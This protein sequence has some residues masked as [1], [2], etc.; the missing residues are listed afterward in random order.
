MTTNNTVTSV[1]AKHLAVGMRVTM[2]SPDGKG[3][4]SP[5]EP[6]TI[7]NIEPYGTRLLFTFNN[8]IRMP[9]NHS[10]RVAVMCISIHQSG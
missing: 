2:D 4:Y 5:A 10:E 9:F 1:P 8:G 6:I 3:A 7:T